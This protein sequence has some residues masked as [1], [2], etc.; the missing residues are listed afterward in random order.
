[1]T[2][3]KSQILLLI[4]IIAIPS[5]AV[6]GWLSYIQSRTEFMETKVRQ[7]F[8]KEITALSPQWSRIKVRSDSE[9]YYSPIVDA[10]QTL[11]LYRYVLEDLNQDESLLPVKMN[12][13]AITKGFGPS[14]DS[15][16]CQ[17]TIEFP[18][19]LGID[20]KVM[21]YGTITIPHYTTPK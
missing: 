20:R 15:L 1:M 10:N 11:E 2:N 17:V 13:P 5:V 16:T 8:D 3:F 4:C 12:P 21:M 14:E 6:F 19:I 7:A 9:T 18:L